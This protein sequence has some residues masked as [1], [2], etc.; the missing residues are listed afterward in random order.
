MTFLELRL[1]D[2]WK[3]KKK[4]SAF[5]RHSW[6]LRT[7]KQP[8]EGGG[9]GGFSKASTAVM[10]VGCYTWLEQQQTVDK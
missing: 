2:D 10:L 8:K 5:G 1:L 4:V 7:Q 3:R 6:I 9:G